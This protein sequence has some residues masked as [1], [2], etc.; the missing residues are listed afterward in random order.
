MQCGSWE[1]CE[2][3]SRFHLFLDVRVQCVQGSVVDAG[4]VRPCSS[5]GAISA[6][7]STAPG[8]TFSTIVQR[9]TMRGLLS[10]AHVAVSGHEARVL[11]RTETCNVWYLRLTPFSSLNLSLNNLEISHEKIMIMVR[12]RR[13]FQLSAFKIPKLGILRTQTAQ[14]WSWA[15]LIRFGRV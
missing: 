7:F 5:S 12:G 9:M 14:E 2:E 11:T 4:P 6:T 8:A 13:T 1:P 10:T 15:T 3:G